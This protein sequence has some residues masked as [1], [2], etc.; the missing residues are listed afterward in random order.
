MVRR[1]AAAVCHRSRSCV[2]LGRDGYA[3]R[4]LR[5][6][7]P[8]ACCCFASR[9]LRCTDYCLTLR[10]EHQAALRRQ[11][12]CS[13][14]QRR[15]RYAGAQR[16]R[17][18]HQPSQTPA[19]ARW[20]LRRGWAAQLRSWR[21]SPCWRCAGIELPGHTRRRRLRRYLRGHRDAAVVRC[22]VNACSTLTRQRTGGCLAFS[23]RLSL[24]AHQRRAAHVSLASRARVPP[25]VQPDFAKL[26]TPLA[27]QR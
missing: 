4:C 8:A 19:C 9:A 17:S 1:Q 7:P 21:P 27:L 26:C 20:R 2:L 12:R 16:R 15:G 25:A 11:R 22:F 24:V 6:S 18:R 10:P 13:A 5:A 3:A 23:Q 14:M